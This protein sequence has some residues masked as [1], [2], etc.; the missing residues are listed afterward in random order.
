MTSGHYCVATVAIISTNLSAGQVNFLQSYLTFVTFFVGYTMNHTMKAHCAL[1]V[2][3]SYY[4][5]THHP[6]C[7]KITQ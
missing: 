3:R 7:C 6:M 5:G 2:V 1:C 4:E